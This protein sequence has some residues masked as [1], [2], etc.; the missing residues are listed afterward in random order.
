[1]PA[2]DGAAAAADRLT[3]PISL[4]LFED[5]VL[6]PCCGNT[7]SRASLRMAL[8]RCPLCRVEIDTTHPGYSIEEAPTNRTVAN[9][10]EEYRAGA[11]IPDEA[12]VKNGSKSAAVATADDGPTATELARACSVCAEPDAR[13]RCSAC[14]VVYY[15]S[16]ECQKY[17]WSGHKAACKR[18]VANARAHKMAREASDRD[19]AVAAARAAAGYGGLAAARDDARAA[20]GDADHDAITLKQDIASSLLSAI[21]DGLTNKKLWAFADAPKYDRLVLTSVGGEG[22]YQEHVI[23][24]GLALEDAD[25]NARSDRGNRK[26]RGRAW[27]TMMDYSLAE[28]QEQGLE[29]IDCAALWKHYASGLQIMD[30]CRSRSG[31]SHYAIRA[32]PSVLGTEGDDAHA[33]VEQMVGESD[34]LRFVLGASARKRLEGKRPAPNTD[35][36]RAALEQLKSMGITTGG[37]KMA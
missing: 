29:P 23:E 10:V 24:A 12:C 16:A 27:W 25:G 33:L 37:G 4:E 34:C 31:A 11:H 15:C 14:R 5:P 36:V 13:Y 17:A 20:D 9:L 18:S 2:L 19:A 3:C 32:D 35:Q 8:P 7:L 26:R 1:M 22:R 30:D 28:L 6:T 21:S